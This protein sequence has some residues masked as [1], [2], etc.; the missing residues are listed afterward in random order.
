MNGT[1]EGEGELHLKYPRF[2]CGYISSHIRLIWRGVFGWGL[3]VGG[4]MYKDTEGSAPVAN[5]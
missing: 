2:L 3:S 1:K 5:Q 4:L